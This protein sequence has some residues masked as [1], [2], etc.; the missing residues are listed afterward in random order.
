MGVPSDLGEEEV[1]AVVRLRG[2]NVLP[3]A[4]LI[5]WCETRLPYFALPRY[6]CFRESLPRTPSERMID[7]KLCPERSGPPAFW[8]LCHPCQENS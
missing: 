6:L 3:P 2:G 7:Q 4:E 8:M 5:S 1:K